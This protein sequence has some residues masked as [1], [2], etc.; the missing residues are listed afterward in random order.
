MNSATT[1]DTLPTLLIRLGTDGFYF[2]TLHSSDHS[3]PTIAQYAID[4]TLSMT[5]N[6]KQFVKD[7]QWHTHSF[8][9]VEVIVATERFTLMPLDH[10]EDEQAD[11]FFGYNL[12]PRENEE[13]GYDILSA[14]NVVVLF[15][16]DRS[17]TRWLKEQIGPVH[18][19]AEA[20]LLIEQFAV[21]QRGKSTQALYA[22]LAESTMEL[23]AF[24]GDKL[25]LANSQRC[26]SA[27]DRLYF[28]LYLWKQLSF[29]AEQGEIHLF[30]EPKIIDP[31]VGQLRKY[32]RHVIPMDGGHTLDF[33]YFISC[34]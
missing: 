6:I 7:Q 22:H 12:S 1:S 20:S 9:R 8:K 15:G 29:D 4:E 24:Q 30:G 21:A 5:A 2:A 27:A 34:E 19:Q 18:L 31:L 14:S 23:Y 25:L 26:S 13:V 11:M 33:K 17:A 28:L 3:R 16:Y 32:I 10:F